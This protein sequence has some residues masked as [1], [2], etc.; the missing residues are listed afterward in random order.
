MTN[1]QT[2]QRHTLFHLRGGCYKGT[3]CLFIEQNVQIFTLSGVRDSLDFDVTS[4]AAEKSRSASEEVA[5]TAKFRLA[6][7][8]KNG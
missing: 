5:Y 4:P 7:I 6:T 1:S 2:T 3:N 8:A